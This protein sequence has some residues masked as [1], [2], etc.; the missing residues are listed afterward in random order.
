MLQRRLAPEQRA[1]A[2]R[3]GVAQRQSGLQFDIHMLVL[4]RRQAALDQAQAAGHA[5]MA[6]QRAGFGTQQQVLGAPFD[7]ED[8]LPGQA[9]IEVLGNRPAQPPLAH[10]HAADALAFEIG[11]D[12]AAGCFDFG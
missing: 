12:A 10:D 6:D 7:L 1:E 11:R 9:H 2:P 4:G 3:V 5:E 8:Q